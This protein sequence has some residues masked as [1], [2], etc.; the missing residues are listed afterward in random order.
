MTRVVK[1]GGRVQGDPSLAREI[2]DAWD[3]QARSLVLVH[4]GG[5]EVTALQDAFGLTPEFV[6]G[7]RVT[8]ARDIDLVRMGLS[9]GVNKRLVS[10]LVHEGVRA[11]GI[12]GEDASLIAATP[13]N[14]A[15][16]GYVGE[17]QRV[18]AS[19]LLHLLDGGYLPV[20]SPVSRN[21]GLELG[22]VLN[23][24]ADDAA[25]AIAAAL[26]AEEL[27]LIA[28]VAGILD[29][30]RVLK[31]LSTG[32]AM[33]LVAR[34]IA[35]GGMAAKVEAALSALRNGVPRVRIGDLSILDDQAGGTIITTK[36][37]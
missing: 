9:G 1:V 3:A 19:L 26:H 30:E 37:E 8:S 27:L 29:G 31:R 25:A 7:R 33:D 15:S 35:D 23:V 5:T 13:V 16:M 36:G 10:A 24:N 14:A 6:Q 21:I 28:D 20:I 11:V 32:Q 4:G 18:N 17:V 34:G 12:S 2:A 22:P